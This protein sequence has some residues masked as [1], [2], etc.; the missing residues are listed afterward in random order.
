VGEAL[1]ASPR[2]EVSPDAS[3]SLEVSEGSEKLSVCLLGA[4]G[5]RYGCAEAWLDLEVERAQRELRRQ[6]LK[7]RPHRV[8]RE[9]SEGQGAQEEEIGDDLEQSAVAR[10]VDRV[11]TTLLAPK[12]ELTQ[13]ELDTLDGNIRQLSGEDALETLFP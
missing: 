2:F 12:V 13:K 3:L 1:A 6:A 9:A 7:G 11:H 8:E 5:D 4:R 10:V